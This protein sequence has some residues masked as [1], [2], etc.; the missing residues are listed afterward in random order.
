MVTSGGS[1]FTIAEQPKSNAEA[2]YSQ[3]HPTLSVLGAEQTSSYLP[4]TARI[5]ALTRVWLP[6]P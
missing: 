6:M 1:V 3:S 5:A 2:R 4:A